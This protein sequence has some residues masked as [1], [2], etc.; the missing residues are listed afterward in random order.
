MLYECFMYIRYD[1]SIL[2]MS[3]EYSYDIW[4]CLGTWRLSSDSCL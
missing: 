3:I 1:H 4:C 2:R